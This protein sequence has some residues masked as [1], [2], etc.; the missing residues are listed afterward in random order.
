MIY[1]RS[2]VKK[3]TGL[4]LLNVYISIKISELCLSVVLGKAVVTI[5]TAYTLGYG[6]EQTPNPFKKKMFKWWNLNY[7]RSKTISRHQ[8]C[9]FLPINLFLFIVWTCLYLFFIFLIFLKHIT[10]IM[11]F[12]VPR[13]LFHYENWELSD[14][15]ALF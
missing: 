10:Q 11:C 4:F 5:I 9:F 2:M 6:S 14:L 15:T 1:P 13:Y 7:W 8:R 12:C 3:C